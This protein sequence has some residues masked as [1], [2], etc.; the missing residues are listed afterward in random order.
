[1]LM[2]GLAGCKIVKN[3]TS[4]KTDPQKPDSFDAKAYVDTLWSSKIL[5]FF[6]SGAHDLAP[7]LSGTAKDFDATNRQYG[8]PPAA[9][10]GAWT[11]AVKGLGRVTATDLKSAHG[12]LTLQV[13]KRSSPSFCRSGPSYLAALSATASLSWFSQNSSTRS[14]TRRFPAPSTRAP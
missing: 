10:G 7:V 14:N 3:G 12:T 1:M 8:Q 5:P 4:D 13:A 2:A 11:F 6:A 9:D